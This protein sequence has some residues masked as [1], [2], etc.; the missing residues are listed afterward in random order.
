MGRKDFVLHGLAQGDPIETALDNVMTRTENRELRLSAPNPLI[1]IVHWIAR[2]PGWAFVLIFILGFGLRLGMVS[3]FPRDLIPPNP[4]W[5]TGAVALSLVRSGEFADPY[6]IPTGPTAHM[7]PLYIGAMS[8]LYRLVGVSFLG[9]LVRWFLVLGVYSVLW[10]LLPWLGG[11]FGLGREAGVLG[12]LAG[13]LCLGFPSE[14]EPFTSLV[15]ALLL[16]SFLV[17]WQ[18]SGGSWGGSFLF[19]LVIGV[20]FHL[21]PALLPVVL[22]CMVFELGWSGNR[23]RW[24]F[25]GLMALGILLACLPWGWRNYTTFHDIF[26]IRSNMGLELYVGNHPGAHSDIDISV[27]RGSFQHPRSDRDEAE[28]V[29]E[30]GERN[31]MREKQRE[32]LAWIGENPAKFLK[33][34]A[35]RA[36]YFWCGPLHRGVSAMGYMTLTLLAFVGAG[37][38]LPT[39]TVPRRAVLLIPLATYPVIYYVLAYMPRYGEPIR[40]ILF[41]LAGAAVWGWMNRSAVPNQA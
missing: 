28:R 19:G 11:R 24:G 29:R 1:S 18:G 15:L 38:V 3:I 32:A 16:M 6:L 12:G 35:L 22:G 4:K 10:A 40:W 9:G 7:P 2:S 31:Y 27:A 21:K 23:R 26:F 36:V 14:I 41:L 5:E 8:L 30:L 33:L 20:A 17:R 13:T 37:W 25:S 34:T 39:L